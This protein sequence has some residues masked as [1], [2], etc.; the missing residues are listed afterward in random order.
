MTSSARLSR[1]SFLPFGSCYLCLELARDPVSC[2]HGDIFCRECA[3]TNLLAQKKEVK[4]LARTRERL[5]QELLDEAARHKQETDQRAIDDFELLQSGF[6]PQLSSTAN[7]KH[8][9][10]LH[11]AT[12]ETEIGNLRKDSGKRKHILS[13]AASEE[14]PTEDRAKARKLGLEKPVRPHAHTPSS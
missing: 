4:R 13:E 8:T 5:K 3:V 1:D 7:E 10:S 9:S 12:S 2:D 14:M 6:A 11:T